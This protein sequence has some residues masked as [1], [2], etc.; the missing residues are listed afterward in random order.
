[1]RKQDK[2]IKDRDRQ[3]ITKVARSKKGIGP[4]KQKRNEDSLCSFNNVTNFVSGEERM[5]GTHSLLMV[6]IYWKTQFCRS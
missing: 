1:M 4:K 2:V 3:L 6:E 5:L